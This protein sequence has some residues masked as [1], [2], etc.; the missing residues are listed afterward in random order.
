DLLDE[1][2]NEPVFYTSLMRHV[3]EP[4]IKEQFRRV[5]EGKS[6]LTDFTFSFIRNRQDSMGKITLEFEVKANSVPSTNIHAIIGRNGVGK[7]TLLNGMI[8]SFINKNDYKD[9]AF[10]KKE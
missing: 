7:T 9:G 1:F 4:T 6:P 2:Q 5:L 3:S 8:K 10:Y